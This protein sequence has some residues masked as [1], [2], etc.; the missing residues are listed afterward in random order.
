MTDRR[1]HPSACRALCAASLGAVF[2]AFSAG[3]ITLENTIP[4]GVQGDAFEGS[5]GAPL[6]LTDTSFLVMAEGPDAAPETADDVV[7][8]VRGIGGT[9][10]VTPLAT[11]NV[12]SYSGQ[13]V[14]VS[15]TRALAI[16]MGVDMT[17]RTADDGVYLL[18][19]LG[20]ANSV[21]FLPIPF[22]ENDEVSLP[23]VLDPETVVVATAGLDGDD[24]T[25]DDTTALVTG[26]G[27]TN[28]ITF[29][30]APYLGYVAEGRPT[31]LSPT[32]FAQ[33]TFGA[34]TNEGG[35]DDA[36]YLFTDVG[37]ANT[38]TTISTPNA[39]CCHAGGVQRVSPTRAVLGSSGADGSD[40]TADDAIWLLDDLGGANIATFVPTPYL[41][42]AAHL[43]AFQGGTVLV[44]FGQGP[45][46]T[47][48]TADDELIVVS[49]L[50]GANTVTP[51]V[52]GALEYGAS[53]AV[54]VNDATAG[55][56]S[57]GP[58]LLDGTADDQ[59]ILVHDVGGANTIERL[60]IGGL[61][62][63]STSFVSP[64]SAATA[65][66]SGGGLDGLL[67]TA[68]DAITEIAGIGATAATSSLPAGG[69]LEECYYL[70]YTPVQ[71]GGGRAVR[72]ASGLDGDLGEGGDDAILV[73][74][75]LP[76]DRGLDVS[77]ARIKFKPTKP[78]KGEKASFKGTLLTDGLPGL[79]GYDLRVTIGAMA[80][81]IPASALVMGK[82]SV[83]Y[84]DKKNLLGFIQK[85]TWKPEKGKIQ[86][87]GKGVMTGLENTDPDYV[88]V[89]VEFGTQYYGRALAGEAKSNGVKYKAPKN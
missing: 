29:L 51:I 24:T 89:A 71:L 82:K 40:G 73:L 33:V 18:D 28:T 59:V 85:L 49:D 79:I 37:G 61:G 32:S 39:I 35:P 38:R 34:D 3:A 31:A 7:L 52:V 16:S 47:H 30:P 1:R 62:Y 78:E 10:T 74:G 22:L 57:Q 17:R 56:V 19:D 66:V 6:A 58:D 5:V 87:K 55:L 77:K 2:L 15:A 27:T 44:A 76:M 45:D 8:L 84:K 48:P 21:T 72:T 83:T 14:R 25:A 43:D 60:T 64:V 9:P 41:S 54:P 81:T 4:F 13:L 63:G 50:F 67:G 36:V 26:L 12:V 46:M 23:I 11:P 20:G 80:Q 68:D 86:V 75:D 65:L 42:Y 88:P 70:G 69:P 53:G